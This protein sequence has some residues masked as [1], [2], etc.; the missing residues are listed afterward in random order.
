MESEISPEGTP[1]Y[2]VYTPPSF[3]ENDEGVF[4]MRFQVQDGKVQPVYL[5]GGDTHHHVQ[6]IKNLLNVQ[7]ESLTDAAKRNVLDK[8]FAKL[9]PATRNSLAAAYP[10][11][12]FPKKV[13][14]LWLS[15]YLGSGVADHPAITQK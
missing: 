2:E 3:K 1:R 13:S 11:V 7:D 6:T 12:T 9:T 15:S 5:D 14:L 10:G 4:E 8:R